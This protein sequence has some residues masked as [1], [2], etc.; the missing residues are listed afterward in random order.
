MPKLRIKIV[1]K[2]FE[3]NYQDVTAIILITDTLFNK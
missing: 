1:I 2:N 3:Q